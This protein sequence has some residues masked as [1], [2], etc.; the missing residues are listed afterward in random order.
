MPTH[1][2][3]PTRVQ[4]GAPPSEEK[5]WT[6][7]WSPGHSAAS[8]RQEAHGGAWQ[9]RAGNSA[10]NTQGSGKGAAGTPAAGP[11]LGRRPGTRCCPHPS[12]GPQCGTR[13]VGSGT[14]GCRVRWAANGAKISSCQD[15]PDLLQG[16]AQGTSCLESKGSFLL[17]SEQR[18][19]APVW[20]PGTPA[21][22]PAH[23]LRLTTRYSGYLVMY[24]M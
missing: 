22:H 19:G 23:L 4:K 24:L 14:P 17:P 11:H 8:G 2:S 20:T 5:L 16:Q 13:P 10:A 15:A 6:W 3:P 1:C 18:S 9:G 21:R 7:N 12:R